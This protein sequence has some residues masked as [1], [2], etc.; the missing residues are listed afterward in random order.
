MNELKLEASLI[1]KEEELYNRASAEA[2]EKRLGMN[3]LSALRLSCHNEMQFVDTF[4]PFTD[5]TYDAEI[6]L[7]KK[8]ELLQRLA[9]TFIKDGNAANICEYTKRFA[10]AEDTS[11]LLQRLMNDSKYMSISKEVE[12]EYANDFVYKFHY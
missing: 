5:T 10:G 4:D 9:T 3:L 12:Q 7:S 6:L 1:T 2:L 11:D 8:S